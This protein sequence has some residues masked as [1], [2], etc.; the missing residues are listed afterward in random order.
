[1]TAPSDLK[2]GDDVRSVSSCP[3][4]TPDPQPDLISLPCPPQLEVGCLPPLRNGRRGRQGRREDHCSS[5]LAILLTPDRL[6]DQRSCLPCVQSKNGNPITRHG[7]AGDP[8]VKIKQNGK[9]PVIKDAHE[10][11]GVTPEKGGEGGEE[12][13]EEDKGAKVSRSLLSPRTCRPL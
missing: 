5:S 3:V 4:P 1:M 10:L 13:E 8:A 12:K 9:N 2:K 7:D 6:S 11:D